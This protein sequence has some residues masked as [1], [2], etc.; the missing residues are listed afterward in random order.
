ME[1]S[2]NESLLEFSKKMRRNFRRNSGRMS[3][4]ISGRLK[5]GCFGKFLNKFVDDYSGGIN[6]EIYGDIPEGN[7]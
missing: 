3:R 4:G 2:P 1:K 5:E 7:S 6:E